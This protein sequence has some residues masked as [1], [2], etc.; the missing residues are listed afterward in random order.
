[1]VQGYHWAMLPVNMAGNA[2]RVP[3]A[4]CIRR[5]SVVRICPSGRVTCVFF[6]ARIPGFIF[7]RCSYCFAFFQFSFADIQAM[8]LFSRS[9]L[10]ALSLLKALLPFVPPL[11]VLVSQFC[12]AFVLFLPIALFL[13]DGSLFTFQ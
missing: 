11:A 8:R 2:G 5:S 7:L 4:V 13:H 1:M 3:I 12:M 10:L 9:L 6:W